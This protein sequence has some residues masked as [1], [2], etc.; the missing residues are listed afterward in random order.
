[1]WAFTTVQA[2]YIA[3]PA[4]L[5]TVSSTNITQNQATLKGNLGNFG[6][7]RVTN[8]GFEY[9]T[10]SSLGQILSQTGL[11]W[12]E[13]YTLPLNNLSCGTTYYYRAYATNPGGT[14]YGK[15]LSFVTGACV[16]I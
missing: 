8:R 15:I 9:G 13:S 16:N 14:A 3:P 7:S 10:T 11:F 1:D 2:I 5:V 6:G 4:G 12:A